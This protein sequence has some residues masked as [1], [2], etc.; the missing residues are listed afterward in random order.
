MNRIGFL[1]ALVGIVAALPLFKSRRKQITICPREQMIGLQVEFDQLPCLRFEVVRQCPSIFQWNGQWIVNHWNNKFIGRH[2]DNG[3]ET[4]LCFDYSQ[5]N[6][7]NGQFDCFE[8]GSNGC[9]A[10]LPA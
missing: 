10:Y 6:G 1:K 2:M 4:L 8:F 9:R 3:S 5:G 7:K